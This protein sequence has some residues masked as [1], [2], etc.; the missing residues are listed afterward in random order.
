ME[1]CTATEKVLGVVWDSM[2][3][4]FHFKVKLKFSLKIK[5]TRTQN[6][7][8]STDVEATY[9]IPDVLTKTTILSQVNSIYDP[10]GPSG[11]YTVR[12]KI[13]IR[14]LWTYETK[15]DWDDPIPDTVTYLKWR[16]LQ[17][18]DVSNHTE[19]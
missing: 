14:K 2:K 5:T 3:D 1:P 19:K 9:N 7:A 15:L 4:N 17:S 13:L 12:A 8:N 16:R 11:P 6:D 10:L 18:N